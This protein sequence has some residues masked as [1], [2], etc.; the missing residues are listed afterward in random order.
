MDLSINGEATGLTLSEVGLKYADAQAFP[1]S[2]APALPD[3]MQF[4]P[5]AD[6][7]AQQAIAL[8][9]TTLSEVAV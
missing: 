5:E 8:Y 6:E 7:M 3:A 4:S 2:I 9:E 1:P